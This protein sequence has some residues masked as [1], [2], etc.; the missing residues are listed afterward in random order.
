MIYLKFDHYVQYFSHDLV[1][2]WH[3]PYV[4]L[5]VWLLRPSFYLS[6]DQ[7]HTFG[8]L[9]QD[10]SVRHRLVEQHRE[11]K[12]DHLIPI[13]DRGRIQTSLQVGIRDKGFI[14]T[15]KHA[16][17]L[18]KNLDVNWE[19]SFVEHFEDLFQKS[20]SYQWIFWL[21]KYF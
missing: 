20:K 8:N 10:K 12:T 3:I 16:K 14:L 6:T 4:V 19:W 7:I 15:R 13:F 9:H 18:N 1:G 2:D 5:K 11:N 17:I 21:P